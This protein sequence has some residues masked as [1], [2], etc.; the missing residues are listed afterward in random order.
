[1]GFST[2]ASIVKEVCEA[3]W[4]KLQ[5]IYM[6]EPTVETWEASVEGFNRL[7]DFPNC[8]GAVD[9][10]HVTIKCPNNSGSD[11]YCYLKM[12]S[13]VLLAIV[14]PEYK[15]IAIDVGA[16]GKNSDGRIFEESAIGRRLENGTLNTP[17]P[18]PLPGSE[19]PIPCVLIGDEAFGLH[20]NLMRP[21]PYRQSRQDERLTNYNYRLCK[22]RRVVENAFGILAKRWR[23]FYRPIEAKTATIN[24]IIKAACVLHNFLR[25]STRNIQLENILP[26]GEDQ[27]RGLTSMEINSR[28]GSNCAMHVREQFVNY[29]NS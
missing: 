10:K 18:R 14:D 29:F 26:S 19:E 7:W 8:L 12:F 22:A 23:I 27:I 9:G 5:P 2:V 4:K 24:S 13:I 21:F 17:E 6:P 15:F 1:M 25:S 11:F 28:R 3:I 16:C 20:Q